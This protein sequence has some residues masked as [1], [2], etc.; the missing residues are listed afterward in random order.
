VV[1]FRACRLSRPFPDR[2]VPIN[3]FTSRIQPNIN[4]LGL[5]CLW[6]ARRGSDLHHNPIFDKNFAHCVRASSRRLFK[7]RRLHVSL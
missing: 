4:C 7:A 5:H 2:E 3:C 1:V 6:Q